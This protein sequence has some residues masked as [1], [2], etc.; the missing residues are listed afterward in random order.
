MIMPSRGE[1]VAAILTDEETGQFARDGYLLGPQ[2]LSEDETIRL[3]GETLRVIDRRD[4]GGVQPDI[5]RNLSQNDAAPVWQ[6]VNIWQASEPFRRLVAHPG[7]AGAIAALTGARQVR[8]WH[9]QIQYKP[10]ATGGVNMWHQDAPYW[11]IIAPATQVTAWIALDAADEDNGCMSMVPGSHR[12][13]NRID[14]LH[15]IPTFDAMAA[16]C[17][18]VPLAV[19]ACP[20]PRGHVHFHHALTFHG[21]GANRS[22][23]PRRAIALHFMTGET[24]FVGSGDHLLKPF[25]TVADGDLLVGD[26]FPLVWDG[27]PVAPEPRSG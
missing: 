3:Q 5:V 1:E 23:R 25:V 16:S 4:A 13:G 27:G 26:K 11:G 7:I 15:A 12:L 22:G 8:L 14:F 18:G 17:D 9:D 6:I 24:R 20:V 2:V 10:A 21:S 19:R